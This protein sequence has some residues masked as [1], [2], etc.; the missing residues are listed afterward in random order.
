MHTKHKRYAK[1]KNFLHKHHHNNGSNTAASNNTIPPTDPRRS[2][3]TRSNI[4]I[5]NP[6]TTA[7]RTTLYSGHNS[8]DIATGSPI[9]AG[10]SS[11]STDYQ[12]YMSTRKMN[13]ERIKELQQQQREAPHSTTTSTPIQSAISSLEQEILG[14]VHSDTPL[15]YP[16]HSAA[17]LSPTFYSAP[18]RSFTA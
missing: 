7:A 11:F 2:S 1:I 6:G 16:S 14:F 9:F 18:F 15:P 3:T 12:R 5:S 4:S 8:S 13:L 17:S 10:N